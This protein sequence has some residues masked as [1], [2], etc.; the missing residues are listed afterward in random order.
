MNLYVCFY[1][2]SFV[3]GVVSYFVFFCKNYFSKKIIKDNKTD[4]ENTRLILL[5][6]LLFVPLL[7]YFFMKDYNYIIPNG[8]KNI[9]FIILPFALICLIKTSYDLGNNFSYTLQIKEEHKLIDTGIYKYIRHPMYFCALLFII[10]QSLLIPNIIGNI[11]NILLLFLFF[12]G[13]IHDEEQMMLKEFGEKY[14]EYMEHTKS[15]IPFIY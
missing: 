14:K 12:Y 11:S 6:V 8:F 2:W 5:V 7:A 13:R 1:L 15:I 3:I 10:G 4:T 9:A